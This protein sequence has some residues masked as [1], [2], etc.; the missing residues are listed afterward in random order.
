MYG[1]DFSS[2]IPQTKKDWASDPPVTTV[3]P[4]CLASASQEVLR[5]DCSSVTLDELYDPMDGDVCLVADKDC[6]V[7]GFALWFDVDF[8]GGG[9][10]AG[11]ERNGTS[12]SFCVAP[13]AP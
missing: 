9:G 12:T 5:I 2:L 10:G 4:T 1:F 6:T 3:D 11:R 7:H 13:S 8:Y